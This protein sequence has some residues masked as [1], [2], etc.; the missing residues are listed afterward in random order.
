MGLRITAK[1]AAPLPSQMKVI[2]EFPR[3]GTVKELQAFFETINFYMYEYFIPK[4]A[5]IILPHTP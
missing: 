1:G 4:A 3:P 5:G 2:S